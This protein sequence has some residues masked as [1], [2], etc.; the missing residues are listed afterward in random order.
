MRVHQGIE[1]YKH[2]DQ[3]SVLTIGTFD[4]VHIGHQKIIQRLNEIKS[5]PFE[6]INDSHFLSTSEKSVGP[7]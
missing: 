5:K 4:G 3:S 6:K 2:K 7:K 1:N